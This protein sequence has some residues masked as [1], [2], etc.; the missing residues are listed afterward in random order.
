MQSTSTM[1]CNRAYSTGS[2]G[3]ARLIRSAMASDFQYDVAD[4]A[5]A[6]TRAITTPTAP[7]RRMKFSATATSTA[8]TTN[9]AISSAERRLLEETWSYRVADLRSYGC[10]CGG[11]GGAG[12]AAAGGDAGGVAGAGVVSNET[13]T[14]SRAVSSA[15]KYSRSVKWNIP[16]STTV[17]NVW[18]LVL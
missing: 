11:A 13:R 15:S 7:N 18:I 6:I 2:A 14:V 1:L 4:R 16:A 8:S 3:R 17:G 12:G 9:A 10:G 5:K